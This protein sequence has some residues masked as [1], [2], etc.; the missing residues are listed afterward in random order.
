MR[1]NQKISAVLC[2][3][4]SIFT[5]TKGIN[6]CLALRKALISQINQKKASVCQGTLRFYSEGMEK[7]HM[8]RPF[9]E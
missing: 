2:L 6:S 3:S 5:L 8:G 1:L 9:P 4:V 7:G